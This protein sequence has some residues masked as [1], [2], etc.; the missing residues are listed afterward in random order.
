MYIIHPVSDFRYY[1]QIIAYL[2][3]ITDV[4]LNT[5]REDYSHQITIYLR[6]LQLYLTIYTPKRMKQNYSECDLI[7]QS[8]NI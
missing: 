2:V 3:F 4:K 1:V 7:D 8:S 6:Y 5:R